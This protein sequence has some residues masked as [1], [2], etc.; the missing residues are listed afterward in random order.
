MKG[1]SD[2]R[3]PSESSSSAA[4]GLGPH[5]TP[6]TYLSDLPGLA[7]QKKVSQ[8]KIAMSPGFCFEEPASEIEP[9]FRGLSDICPYHHVRAA[10]SA[11][12]ST[13]TGFP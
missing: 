10:D 6:L 3:L 9:T 11:L 7:S 8:S 5:P 13:V 4:V 2:S 12:V 1:T